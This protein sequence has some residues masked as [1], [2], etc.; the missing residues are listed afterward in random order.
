[1]SKEIRGII[2]GLNVMVSVLM[3]ETLIRYVFGD[4]YGI[5]LVIIA[6]TL[7]ICLFNGLN[8][9]EQYFISIGKGKQEMRGKTNGLRERAMVAIF[10]ECRGSKCD[11]GY[12]SRRTGIPETTLRR[13]KREPDMIP[14]NRLVLIADA[15]DMDGDEAWYLLKGET[16]G[17]RENA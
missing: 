6:V 9:T 3:T 4:L 13:Y 2:T 16:R 10:R 12:L 7:A 1:M 17:I 5:R 14:L 11:L 15:M 8:C